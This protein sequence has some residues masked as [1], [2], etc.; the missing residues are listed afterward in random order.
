[1]YQIVNEYVDTGTATGYIQRVGRWRAAIVNNIEIPRSIYLSVEYTEGLDQAATL[2]SY[3]GITLKVEYSVVRTDT[4]SYFTGD[5]AADYA[6]A[7]EWS[8]GF[9]QA[10]SN[11]PFYAS[12][13]LDSF[14]FTSGYV[15]SV[16]DDEDVPFAT[17]ADLA[18]DQIASQAEWL[19]R[20]T[21]SA[22]SVARFTAVTDRAI[23]IDR[24]LAAAWDKVPAVK[25]RWALANVIA[26]SD[27]N[28]SYPGAPLGRAEA[29]DAI[30]VLNDLLAD[31]AFAEAMRPR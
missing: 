26:S 10:E 20:S 13:T 7:I 9:G 25:L 6:A 16:A 11:I 18:A 17:E 21:P 2:A 14:M 15:A 30:A 27:Y 19:A 23:E 12:S 1:M 3:K 28:T 24:K 31:E 4:R 29:M 22:E 5:F 8:Q